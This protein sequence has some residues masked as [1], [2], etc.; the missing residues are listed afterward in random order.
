MKI[1]VKLFLFLILGVCLCRCSNREKKI[2]PPTYYI[3]EVF[4]KRVPTSK[5][6]LYNVVSDSILSALSKYPID[7]I[8]DDQ[9]K[10]RHWKPIQTEEEQS[11]LIGFIKNEEKEK[12]SNI[13]DSSA[14]HLMKHLTNELS[15]NKNKYLISYSYD[16]HKLGNDKFEY[17][18]WLYLYIYNSHSGQFIF[19]TNAFR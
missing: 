8:K 13:E 11:N 16:G 5:I 7:P 2:F 17:T 18:E 19:L 3:K 10:V 6:V 15:K 1:F 12:Y 14:I 9:W 4:S